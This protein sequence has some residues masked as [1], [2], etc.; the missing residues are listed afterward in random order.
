L[1]IT[2]YNPPAI[3]NVRKRKV[4]KQNFTTKK[5]KDGKGKVHPVTGH[6]GS[7]GV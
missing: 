1:N 3:I 4:P 2:D 5:Q 6:E 7:K